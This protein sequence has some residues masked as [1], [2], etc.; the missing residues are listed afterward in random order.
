M[1]NLHHEKHQKR[2]QSGLF[3]TNC[4][5]QRCLHPK[6]TT[7]NEVKGSLSDSI[8]SSLI[9]LKMGAQIDLFIRV[10]DSLME[11]GFNTVLHLCRSLLWL[12]AGENI[13]VHQMS[14]IYN[15]LGFRSIKEKKRNSYPAANKSLVIVLSLADVIKAPVDGFFYKAW[16]LSLLCSVKSKQISFFSCFYRINNRKT[17][18]SENISEFLRSMQQA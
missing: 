2:T 3:G 12:K 13:F 10:C 14:C 18:R 15:L 16:Q 7:I 8:K 5:I 1:R 6:Q 9:R 11:K 17:F 4:S